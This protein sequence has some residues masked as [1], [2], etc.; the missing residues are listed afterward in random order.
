MNNKY[1]TGR[2][3]LHMLEKE[4]TLALLRVKQVNP[5]D[6]PEDAESRFGHKNMA[7]IVGNILGRKL[8]CNKESV[9]LKE[10]D[11]LYVALHKGAFIPSCATE[12][13]TGATISFM[14]I[15]LQPI[16]GC[17]DCGINGGED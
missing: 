6:V 11:V 8:T 12:L 5:Q 1:L 7:A 17:R 10:G 3:S 15:T 4:Q 2:F 16:D 13:P 14:E 9:I